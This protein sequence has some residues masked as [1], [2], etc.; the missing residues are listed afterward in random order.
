MIRVLHQYDSFTTRAQRRNER[1]A[2]CLMNGYIA[3]VKHHVVV[4]ISIYCCYQ[5]RSAVTT[6]VA[7]LLLRAGVSSP[8]WLLYLV[9]E[10]PG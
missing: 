1:F 2:E 4:C 3:T 9:Y 8:V 7:L 6:V 10:V 5:Y